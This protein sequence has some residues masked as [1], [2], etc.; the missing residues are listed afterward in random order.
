MSNP[1]P[2]DPW[3]TAWQQ[4][5]DTGMRDP[6]GRG[7]S[8]DIT[9]SARMHS[10]VEI[11]GVDTAAPAISSQAHH[12]APSHALDS[13][14]TVVDT[15]TATPRA[16]FDAPTVRDG[17][18]SVGYAG[19]ANMGGQPRRL[20]NGQRPVARQGFTFAITCSAYRFRC[21]ILRSSGS[22]SGPTM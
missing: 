14:M 7:F 11:S 1:Y 9:A 16:H 5:Y 2:D 6:D 13:S 15:E 8:S 21:S 17:V 20:R 3:Q 19:A 18:V 22:V 10:E 4:G 12:C